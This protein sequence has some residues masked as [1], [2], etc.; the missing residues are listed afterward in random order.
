MNSDMLFKS[1]RFVH[2]QSKYFTTHLDY[3]QLYIK[4]L[5]RT[6]SQRSREV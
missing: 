1:T 5:A 6:V 2:T 4:V 3:M